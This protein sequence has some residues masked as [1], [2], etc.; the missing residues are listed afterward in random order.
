MMLGFMSAWGGAID[1]NARNIV[2]GYLQIRVEAQFA[3]L[4]ELFVH[5]IESLF[6]GQRKTRQ[7]LILQQGHSP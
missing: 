5:V 6:G 2:M 4:K 3:L 1:F 7:R